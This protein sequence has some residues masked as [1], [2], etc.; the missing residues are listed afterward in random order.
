M[1]VDITLI[2]K[3]IYGVKRLKTKGTYLWNHYMLANMMLII[4]LYA[5]YTDTYILKGNN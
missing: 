2:L 3:K 5:F 4:G 1:L